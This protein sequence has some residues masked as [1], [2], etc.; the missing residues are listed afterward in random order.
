MANSFPSYVQCKAIPPPQQI[1]LVSAKPTLKHI[2]MWTN[3][4]KLVSKLDDE[5]VDDLNIDIMNLIGAAINKKR[6]RS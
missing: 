4:D 3:F 6:D 2:E 5:A 1:E